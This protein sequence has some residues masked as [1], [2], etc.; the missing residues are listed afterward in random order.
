MM[1]SSKDKIDLIPTEPHF[2]HLKKETRSLK[3][4]IMVL[5]TEVKCLRM[6][7]DVLE[8]LCIIPI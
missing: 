8:N 3:H 7:H 2:S 5:N 1:N 6:L 4:E